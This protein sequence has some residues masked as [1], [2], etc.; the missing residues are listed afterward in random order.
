MAT[1][2]AKGAIVA[3]G[4]L[5][6]HLLRRRDSPGDSL[7]LFRQCPRI[8]SEVS[9]I[10]GYRGTSL[11]SSFDLPGF[12]SQQ[13]QV[14][15]VFQPVAKVRQADAADGAV[16]ARVKQGAVAVQAGEGSPVVNRLLAISWPRHA[17]RR[18]LARSWNGLANLAEARD[19]GRV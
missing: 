15:V 16:F 18:P 7:P 10:F 8:A 4:L 19:S 12:L 9:Q 11:T 5:L 17:T 2:A 6:G 14:L 3:A 1:A 13:P